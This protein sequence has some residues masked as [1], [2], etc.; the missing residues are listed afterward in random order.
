M[1][2]PKPFAPGR[3]RPVRIQTKTD[4][5]LRTL[6]SEHRK[7]CFEDEDEDELRSSAENGER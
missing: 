1:V 6:N 4:A 3:W 5:E 2:R 7:H